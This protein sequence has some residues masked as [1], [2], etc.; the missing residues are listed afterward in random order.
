MVLRAAGKDDSTATLL[1]E[2]LAG[3]QGEM[4]GAYTA[5]S[6]FLQSHLGIQSVGERSRIL[7]T[8]M[9][10]NSLYALRPDRKGA[11]NG[12]ARKATVEEMRAVVEFL[13]SQGLTLDQVQ[14]VVSEHPP[15]LVYDIEQRLRPTF[16]YL[17][18][19]GMTPAATVVRRPS[20]LGLGADA[21]LRR[22]VGYLQEVDGR[23]L[24]E[25]EEL[26]ATTL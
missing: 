26:L 7:D 8:A 20:L 6:A 13:Q 11:V 16:E 3:K 25:I 9:N 1:R 21:S 24:A 18:S 12:W 4:E 2:A 5:G 23:S 22:I 10:P 14:K 19:L 15:T 17:A